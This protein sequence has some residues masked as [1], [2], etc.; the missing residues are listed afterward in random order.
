MAE[1]KLEAFL[2]T[3]LAGIC[4][5]A[6]FASPSALTE[7]EARPEKIDAAFAVRFD[8]WKEYIGAYRPDYSDSSA[9]LGAPESHRLEKPSP[10]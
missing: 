3:A 4:A 7:D 5:T 9:F 10:S 2:M 1:L 6:V 8:G